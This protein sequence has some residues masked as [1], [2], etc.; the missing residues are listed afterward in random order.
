MNDGHVRNIPL[1]LLGVWLLLG[2]VL[3]SQA[4]AQ[5]Q[6]EGGSRANA[7]AAQTVSGTQAGSDA[8]ASSDAQAGQGGGAIANFSA[9]MSLIQQT[10]DPLDWMDGSSV[11]SPFPSGVYIDAAG[12][13]KH[14]SSGADALPVS[15]NAPVTKLRQAWRA[16]SPQR[17]I[18]L[19]K[20]DQAL[21]ERVASGRRVSLEF[22]RL[23]G[24]SRIEYVHIDVANEDVWLVGPAAGARAAVP[25]GFYLADLALL[26]ELINSRSTPLGC[27]ID[28]TDAGILAA[29]QLLTPA[30]A[31]K[32]LSV[33]PKKFV[34][35]MQDKIGPHHV[36]VFGMP[37]SSPAALALVLADEHMK[38]IAFETARTSVDMESYF[39]H[40]DKQ[41]NVPTQ[42]LIRW[43]F[44][45][46]NKPIR[47]NAQ[48]DLFQLPEQCVALYSEQQWVSLTGLQPTG[49]QDVAAD[50]FAKGMTDGLDELRGA[51]PAYA[52][53][54]ALFESAL[55]LQLALESNGQQ[56]L[57]AWF[58]NLEQYARAAC[59][60]LMEPKTV[61]GL[62]AWHKLKQG[63][64]VAVVSGG[65]LINSKPLASPERWQSASIAID[66]PLELNRFEA[67]VE[68]WW[69]D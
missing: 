65:V 55:A 34:G 24:L 43:W 67:N 66:L 22:E 30:G 38:R 9:L 45:F 26:V 37:A 46:A 41:S 49:E 29:Q 18:S 52:R 5:S 27:S 16:E 64:V 62:T 53:L 56:N 61:S 6:S 58:P 42:S 54:C 2:A 33:N 1:H 4:Q 17:I 36:R 59:D 50:A 3:I 21:G 57:H 48:R 11:M 15:L 39:D 60:P 19:R 68:R 35:Q 13:L 40:L 23:A 12:Q 25:Q 32:R 44:A 20:L 63:T 8:Q 31:L 14:L 51:H 10:I 47:A 7:S 28:P 69:W